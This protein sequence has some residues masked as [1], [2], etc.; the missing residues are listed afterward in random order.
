[1]LALWQFLPAID[2][3]NAGGESFIQLWTGLNLAFVAWDK[4][5]EVL[6][7]PRIKCERMIETATCNILETHR[8]PL[9]NFFL[10]WSKVPALILKCFW[11]VCGASA[12]AAFLTGVYMLY[13]NQT[14]AWDWIMI[15]PTAAYVIFAFINLGIFWAFIRFMTMCCKVTT[16]A[17][18]Q[19]VKAIT[20]LDKE[21]RK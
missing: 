15:L 16:P 6:D 21:T 10:R 20:D 12:G 4:Y 9:A 13:A 5:Q 14:G 2:W 8:I 3:P 18:A 1:V 17:E 19:I 11:C 7:W